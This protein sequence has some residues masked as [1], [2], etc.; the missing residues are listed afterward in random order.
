MGTLDG[1][2]VVRKA[3]H[4]DWTLGGTHTGTLAL[5][6]QEGTTILATDGVVVSIADGATVSLG[7][8]TRSLGTVSGK[9][10]I[11]N[12]TVSTVLAIAD[13]SDITLGA[14]TLPAGVTLN[15]ASSVTFAGDT[16]LTGLSVHI[17]DPAAVSA[18]LKAV[19]SVAGERT[20]EPTFSFGERGYT[21]K[22]TED[23]NGYVIVLKGFT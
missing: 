13:G 4:G 12:G 20:G 16:D 15:G 9:G 14:V 1:D 22:A 18:S 8:A 3:G 17:A 5:D 21:A 10:T 2:V 6:A 23:G 19:V 7:G 11:T